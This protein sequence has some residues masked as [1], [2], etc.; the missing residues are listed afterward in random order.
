MSTGLLIMD[1]AKTSCSRRAQKVFLWGKK[2]G[3]CVAKGGGRAECSDAK[4]STRS[5]GIGHDAPRSLCAGQWSLARFS[6]DR[7]LLG[8]LFGRALADSS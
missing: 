3:R 5:A 4:P 7:S 1:F 8:D 2:R 6:D